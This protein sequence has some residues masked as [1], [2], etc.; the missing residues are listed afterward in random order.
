MQLIEHVYICARQTIVNKGDYV[1]FRIFFKFYFTNFL[2]RQGKMPLLSSDFAIQRI[3]QTLTF[4]AFLERELMGLYFSQV[5]M[6]GYSYLSMLTCQGDQLFPVPD[7]CS[8][9]FQLVQ[10]PPIQT[11]QLFSAKISYS[12][13]DRVYDLVCSIF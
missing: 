1:K 13:W 6:A 3:L 2:V 8:G 10:N 11:L 9:T 12:F 5:C 7:F 4:K